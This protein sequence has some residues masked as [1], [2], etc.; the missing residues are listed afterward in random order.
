MTQPE[1]DS[2]V[3]CNILLLG[4][5]TVQDKDGNGITPRTQKSQ[6]LL[7]MLAVSPRGSRS[8]SW[9]RDKLWSDRSEEQSSASLRQALL[10]IRRSFNDNKDILVA[11][12]HTVTLDLSRVSIDLLEVMKRGDSGDFPSEIDSENIA[13]HLFEGIDIHDPEFEEWLTLERQVWARRFQELAKSQPA[14]AQ[15][16]E[17]P[18]AEGEQLTLNTG[19]SLPVDPEA[20]AWFVSL[21][22]PILV[23]GVGRV[24]VLATIITDA[25]ANSLLE[26]S[27]IRLTNLASGHLIGAD[28]GD[29]ISTADGS[30]NTVA[31]LAI[32]VRIVQGSDQHRIGIEVLR[33][34]DGSMIWSAGSL[35]SEVAVAKGDIS[36]AYGL[37]RRTV[38]QVVRFFIIHLENDSR[39]YTGKLFEAVYAM[40][41]LSA[42]N[43]DKGENILRKIIHE[44]PSAQAYAWL[45][46]LQTF[47]LGQRFSQDSPELISEV[48]YNAFRALEMDDENALVLALSGHVHSYLLGEYDVAAAQFE[49][50]IR[51]NPAQPLGWDLYAMLLSYVGQPGKAQAMANWVQNLGEFSPY[52]YYFETTKCISATLAGDHI[53][54]I[55]V[56]EQALSQRP[57][58]NS[59]LRTMISSHAHLGNFDIAQDLL[60]RLLVIE[61]DF[62]IGAML[63]SGYP[64]MKT[65][66]GLHY[67]EGLVKGGVSEN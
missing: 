24:P 58:F 17:S 4:P 13:E 29:K 63:E 26:A 45:G 32:Q 30:T 52:S 64:G 38:D 41:G 35:I 10:D 21:L 54:S 48:K 2:S 62:S 60:Q 53:T 57:Q 67:M 9:L 16:G 33:T 49:K 40:F 22:E 20:Q 25:L 51:I 12:R 46:F 15:E 47:R 11:D 59:I 43:L 37:I 36:S 44:K 31:P 66:G 27:D 50:A 61:P 34:Y 65:S 56:G 6:A 55:Q 28:S 18:T 42:D 7:A 1:T 8:R 5:I 19:N 39:D 3:R 23:G 14:A